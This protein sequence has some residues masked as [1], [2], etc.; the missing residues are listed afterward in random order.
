M[1]EEVRRQVRTIKGLMQGKAKPDYA[2]AVDIATVNA[3]KS[4][5]VPELIAIVTPIAVGLILG[6]GGTWRAFG[7]HDTL[8]A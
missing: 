7:R 6:K 2:K 5:A 8:Q 1:V 4:L 3:I